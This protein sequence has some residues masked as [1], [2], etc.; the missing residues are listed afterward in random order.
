MKFRGAAPQK[1]LAL[2]FLLFVLTATCK[3]S[4]ESGDSVSVDLSMVTKAIDWLEFIRGGA[5]EFE[6]KDYFMKEVAPTRGCKSI[7]HH[8]KRF[9]KWDNDEFY[10]FIM[11]ALGKAPTDKQPKD[12]EGN[13]TSFGRR[14]IYWKAALDD[15]QRLRED[16]DELVEANLADTALALAKSYLPEDS[17]VACKFFI[18]LFGGSSAYAVSGENGFD[19]LQLPKRSDGSVDVGS[20]IRTFAHEMHH[21]GIIHCQKEKMSAVRD[22]ERLGLVARLTNEGMPIYYINQTRNRL[23]EYRSSTSP[24]Q[25]ADARDWEEHLARLPELYSIAEEHIK[26]NL[27][28]ELSDEDIMK[29]WMSGWSQGPVYTLGSDMFS[30]IDSVLGL[31]AA[32]Q[33]AEDYRQLLTVYNRA[34]RKANENGASHYVFSEKLAQALVTYTGE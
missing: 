15:P 9:M 31:Q 11:Q 14:Q 12:E 23:D 18:V 8:W 34:A 26:M 33:V 1:L 5:D 21:L 4:N 30:V 19:L 22:T 17:R 13:L 6:V 3:Q 27:E 2:I 20:V 10:N 29:N 28:G 7:I 16:L 25:Q 24:T 32:L